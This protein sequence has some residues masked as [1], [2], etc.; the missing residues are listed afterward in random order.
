VIVTSLTPAAGVS[1]VSLPSVTRV[2]P[3][4][5]VAAWPTR[6]WPSLVHATADGVAVV[7]HDTTLHRLTG[8]PAAVAAG[9][10]RIATDTDTVPGAHSGH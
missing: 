5:A 9:S 7:F 10:V 3:W 1:R 8:H 2:P 6:R 4:A